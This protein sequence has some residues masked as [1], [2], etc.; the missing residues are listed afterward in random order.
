[1]AMKLSYGNSW[2]TDATCDLLTQCNG[3]YDT[4][5]AIPK[6]AIQVEF[7]RQE[8][9]FVLSQEQVVRYSTEYYSGANRSQANQ[10][11]CVW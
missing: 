11:P 5:Y 1:M 2:T 10:T 8:L 6:G 9:G 4:W 7:V 3:R